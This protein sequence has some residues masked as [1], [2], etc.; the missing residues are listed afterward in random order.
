MKTQVHRQFFV[1]FSEVR[2]RENLLAVPELLR[3]NG[4]TDGRAVHF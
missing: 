3:A 4:R 1:T 2:L